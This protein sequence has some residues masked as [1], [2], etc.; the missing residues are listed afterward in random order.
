VPDGVNVSLSGRE[1]VVQSGQKRLTFTHR[2]DVSVRLDDQTKSVVVERRDDSRA[3][4]ALHG[5]TRS[6]IAN[7]IAGVVKDFSKELEVNGVGWTVKVQG[8]RLSLSVG[9]ADARELVVPAGLAVAVERN[10]IRVS[11]ADK[12]QVGQF[13]AEVRRQRPPEPYNGKGIKYSDERVVR[14]QGKAFAAGGA[15]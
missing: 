10:R 3:A 13:A 9:Y 11:G 12:Q 15:A 7:M 5:T 8:N 6:M 4:R 1:V 2:S 14:K